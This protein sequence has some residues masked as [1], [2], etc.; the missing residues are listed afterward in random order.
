MRAVTYNPAK[1]VGIDGE[2]GVIKKGRAADFLLI[3]D[4]LDIKAVYV[5]GKRIK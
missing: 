5:D 3:D 4:N 2:Y 1:A